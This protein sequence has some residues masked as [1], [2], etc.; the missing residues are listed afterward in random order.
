MHY[1]QLYFA[2][3]L[4]RRLKETVERLPYHALG[5][6]L[7]RH[8][9]VVTLSLLNLTKHIVDACLAHRH[10][11][12]TEMFECRCLRVSALWPKISH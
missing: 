12:L 7:D 9:A 11:R 6:I 2:R 1:G 3:D 10:R 8:H 4:Q 5:R